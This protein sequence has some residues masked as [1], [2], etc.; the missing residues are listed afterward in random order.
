M[1]R[2]RQLSFSRLPSYFVGTLVKNLH[3]AAVASSSHDAKNLINQA[4]GQLRSLEQSL[5]QNLIPAAEQGEAVSALVLSQLLA[6]LQQSRQAVETAADKITNA[7]QLYVRGKQE[8][9]YSNVAIYPLA[10]EATANVQEIIT[11]NGLTLLMDVGGEN[12]L[13]REEWVMARDCVGEA[14]TNALQNAVRY[15]ASTILLQIKDSPESLRLEVHD[16]GPGY[17]EA[18]LK[19]HYDHGAG[20]LIAK[21][22]IHE[23]GGKL[24]LSNESTFAHGAKFC[25]EIPAHVD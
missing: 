7:L 3:R 17:P 22:H 11:R 24:T 4:I 10:L 21:E 13:Q 18:V 9:F 2:L 14:L 16:D 12:G 8:H 1:I 6:S 25:M 23:V 19:G 5:S 15:A 20:L